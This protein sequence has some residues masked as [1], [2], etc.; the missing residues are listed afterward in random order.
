MDFFHLKDDLLPD[1]IWLGFNRTSKLLYFK[2]APGW[3]M[4]LDSYDFIVKMKYLWTL[5]YP[6]MSSTIRIKASKHELAVQRW[7]GVS[8]HTNTCD[9]T[10]IQ[11]QE[12]F[13]KPHALR[14]R[15]FSVNAW[16][17]RFIFAEDDHGYVLVPT[18]SNKL[19]SL[20]S[21]DIFV[22]I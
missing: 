3:R 8:T 1:M 18:D 4:N 7:L 19:R 10:T 21:K 5:G 22:C 20:I 11:F 16:I 15:Y 14:N 13:I 2:F 6:W 17:W 12:P 9:D